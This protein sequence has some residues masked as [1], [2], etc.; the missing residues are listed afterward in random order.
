[1]GSTIYTKNGRPVQVRDDAIWSRS[2]KYVGR[3]VDGRLYGPNGR[4][5]ATLDGD[6]LVTR[7]T[8]RAQV[9]GASGRL[10]NIGGSGAARAGRS[11]IWGQEPEIPD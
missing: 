4:Y 5:I 1:M 3:L 2:G 11:G 9:V 6:R 10:A 7:S 8:D